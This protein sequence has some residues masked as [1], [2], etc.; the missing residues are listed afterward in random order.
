MWTLTMALLMWGIMGK[1]ENQQTL[2]DLKCDPNYPHFSVGDINLT[3]ETYEEYKKTHPVFL[4]GLS[5]S[6]CEKCCYIEPM[7]NL[8]HNLLSTRFLYKGKPVPLARINIKAARGAFATDLPALNY[9]PKI[10]VFKYIA[11]LLV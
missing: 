11:S 3:K 6:E 1:N 2:D 5:D 8:L 9:Y 7:L 4:L 10:L